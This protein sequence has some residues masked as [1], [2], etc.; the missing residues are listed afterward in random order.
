MN[1]RSVTPAGHGKCRIAEFVQYRCDVEKGAY[2]QP[3]FHCWP[4][5]R[6]FRICPGR[7]A[8]EITRFVDVDM[9]TGEI[10]IPPESSQALPKGKAWRDVHRYEDKASEML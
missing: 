4:V 3:Q 9:H 5:P 1:V 7:P 6:I 10:S 2:G 8:V